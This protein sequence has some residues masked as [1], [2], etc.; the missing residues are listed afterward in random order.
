M[1]LPSDTF[2]HLLVVQFC[3]PHVLLL[4]ALEYRLWSPDVHLWGIHVSQDGN[5][6]NPS[7]LLGTQSA[8]RSLN[9][10][11]H[12]V[13]KIKLFYFYLK[14]HIP[15]QILFLFIFISSFYREITSIF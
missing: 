11:Y 8:S 5:A 1:H 4:V 12:T 6:R 13:I 14:F 9:L 10:P 15:S 7:W 2:G 3:L